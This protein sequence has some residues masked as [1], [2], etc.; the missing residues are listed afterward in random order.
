MPL[1]GFTS[2]GSGAN[3]SL[4]VAAS[5]LRKEVAQ[6]LADSPPHLIAIGSLSVLKPDGECVTAVCST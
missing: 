2:G 4:T 3:W 6:T 1:P 5:W